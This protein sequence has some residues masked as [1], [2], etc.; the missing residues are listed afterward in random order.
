MKVFISILGLGMCLHIC[1]CTHLTPLIQHNDCIDEMVASIDAT[2]GGSVILTLDDQIVNLEEFFNKCDQDNPKCALY[3]KFHFWPNK[4][5]TI[6]SPSKAGI[7]RHRIR[8]YY[9]PSS[10]CYPERVNP[11]RIYGDVAEFYDIYNEFMGIAVYMGE[12]AYYPLPFSRYNR[13]IPIFPS[14]TMRN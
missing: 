14:F 6:E 2:Q 3:R 7:V 9:S 10:I 5:I 12:G 4:I 8:S 1:C 13:G 11:M